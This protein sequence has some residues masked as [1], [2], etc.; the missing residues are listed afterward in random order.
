L[1]RPD[2]LLLTIRCLAR[3]SH[4]YN[5]GERVGGIRLGQSQCRLRPLT[6]ASV[7]RAGGAESVGSN[8]FS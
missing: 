6:Y 4:A 2:E 7:D 8:S 5:F 1:S 3:A